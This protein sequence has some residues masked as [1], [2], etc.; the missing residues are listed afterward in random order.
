MISIIIPVRNGE[1]Y[2][3]EALV[4]IRKQDV[5]VEIVVVDDA[6]TDRTVEIAERYGCKVIR[7]EI[8]KGQ[9]AGKNTGIKYATGDF[10]LFHDHDDLL[11]DGALKVLL[12]AFDECTYAVE[13]KVKD[14]YTQGMTE[15]QKKF[16]AIKDEAYWGL[17]TGAIM[18][19]RSV[20]DTIG[21]FTESLNTGEI[22]EWEYRMNQ[23]SFNIKKIDFISTDRR[24]HC[25]N[26]GKTDKKKE[27]KD[28][29]TVLRAMI[30]AKKSSGK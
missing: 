21:E 4:N 29:A 28:Y 15:E 23:N 19:R 14:F 6:S 9:V 27:Y 26:Y 3:E 8:C 2:L 20:F 13:A 11:R 7:H 16:S 12:D 1:N 5:E 18:M 24:V 17:F 25:S 22:I 30:L 10:V